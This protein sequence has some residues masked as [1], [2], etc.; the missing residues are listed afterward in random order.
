LPLHRFLSALLS[1]ISTFLLI[2]RE[3]NGHALSSAGACINPFH[4]IILDPQALV[5]QLA[6]HSILP[7]SLR[8]HHRMVPALELCR[9]LQAEL[10]AGR[11]PFKSDAFN[12]LLVAIGP[13]MSHPSGPSSNPETVSA[14]VPALVSAP[15]S[16]PVP[17][18]TTI[19]LPAP[20]ASLSPSRS[21]EPAQR[22]TKQSMQVELPSAGDDFQRR[23]EAACEDD[24]EHFS[25]DGCSDFASDS[26]DDESLEIAEPTSTEDDGSA[27]D[28]RERK[29]LATHKRKY[30]Q[31]YNDHERKRIPR[32]AR[33]DDMVV[34]S[35][36]AE[37]RAATGAGTSFRD[38][39][40][41]FKPLESI[42]LESAPRISIIDGDSDRQTSPSR[43][44]SPFDALLL[45]ISLAD[46]NSSSPSRPVSPSQLK[47][48]LPMSPSPPKSPR[49]G[50]KA[51]N[52]SSTSSEPSQLFPTL[53]ADEAACMETAHGH[54]RILP[55]PSVNDPRF[56][57]H[58]QSV[59]YGPGMQQFPIASG[60][61]VAFPS[62]M[63]L[64]GGLVPMYQYAMPVTREQAQF[65][66]YLHS[67]PAP[68]SMPTPAPASATQVSNPVVRTSRNSPLRTVG[69]PI[70]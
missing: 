48:S 68:S 40:S 44:P 35:S 58:P 45:A 51:S 30:S 52:A 41:V 54:V 1:F 10:A 70:I 13:P 8:A 59:V 34:V 27:R 60:T 22:G 64:P 39:T 15:I 36:T 28:C 26:S 19:A 66:S 16:A 49:I 23:E 17:V 12:L 24:S 31:S 61:V 50:K 3:C 20:A 65:A 4:Y 11:I 42:L 38:V 43:Q 47:G 21:D 5:R 63:L 32:I 18:P 67:T 69:R 9:H 25:E 2:S 6:E 14:P 33:H 7:A 29:S 53:Q 57:Q 46:K 55:A 37:D 56:L 62:P